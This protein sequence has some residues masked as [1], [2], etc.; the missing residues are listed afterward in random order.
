V[1]GNHDVLREVLRHAATD[2]Q[3]ARGRVLDLDLR[4]LVEVLAGINGAMRL[5]LARMHVRHDAEAERAVRER[6]AEDRHVLLVAGEHDRVWL[7]GCGRAS[8]LLQV[9][10]H[11]ADELA[12]AVRSGLHRVDDLLGGLVADAELFLVDE[13]VV[14]AVDHQLAEIGIARAVLVLVAGDV[15]AEAEGLEEVLVDDVRS[16]RD[17]GID[18]VVAYQVDDDLLQAGRDERAGEAEDDAA[19]GVAEHHVIDVGRTRKIARAVGHRS[20]R[21][22]QRHNVVLGDIDVLNLLVEEFLFGSHV[23]YQFIV[24][25][26]VITR[27]FCKWWMKIRQASSGAATP[28]DRGPASCFRDRPGAGLSSARTAT[29]SIATQSRGSPAPMR[30]DTAE[31]SSF[32]KV[33]SAE[34]SYSRPQNSSSLNCSDERELRRARAQPQLEAGSDRALAAR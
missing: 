33:L 2:H 25:P 19:L 29:G 18:H 12:R 13:R 21:V 11:L 4:Q 9:A 30:K 34:S 26:P 5:A 10:S 8:V 32:W 31:V 15:V 24:F 28:G 17:D 6:R 3:Q 27:V 1:G 16:G 23:S 7:A 22:H 14:D 20:H